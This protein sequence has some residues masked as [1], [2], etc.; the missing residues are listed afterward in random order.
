MKKKFVLIPIFFIGMA[1]LITWVLMLL[2]NWL[3]PEIF[4][5]TTITFWQA[6]GL[7]AISKLL[8]GGF[9]G[10]KRC[11]CGKQGKRAHWKEKFKQ[12]WENMSDDDKAKWEHKFGGSKWSKTAMQQ[13]FCDSKLNSTT[14]EQE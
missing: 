1:A 6:L 8:F 14:S 2:W 3:M 5:L 7:L 4:N 10:N 11:N 12:K 9:S 13:S